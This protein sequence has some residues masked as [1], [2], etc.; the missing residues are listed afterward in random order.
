MFRPD[1]TAARFAYLAGMALGL[2]LLAQARGPAIIWTTG[3][4]RI[5]LLWIFPF[6]PMHLAVG[7]DFYTRFP[8]AISPPGIW[9]GIRVALYIVC[10]ALCLQGP[11][12]STVASMWGDVAL[13][14]IREQ[15]AGFDV[16]L[17]WA[18]LVFPVTGVGILSVLAH[19]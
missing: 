8:R 2:F 17:R 14:A 11:L 9:G 7:Y 1:E 10:A 19:N 5:V 18:G 4:Q 15:L 3:W 16:G 13:L 12:A 6:N